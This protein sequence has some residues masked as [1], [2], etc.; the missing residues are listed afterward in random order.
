[1][2]DAVSPA[3]VAVAVVLRACDFGSA[4]VV[5]ADAAAAMVAA[6]GE[7]SA[8]AFLLGAFGGCSLESGLAGTSAAAAGG[9][10]LGWWMRFPVVR[11]TKIADRVVLLICFRR[12]RCQY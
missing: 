12:V 2:V 9:V 10:C 5:A 1:M 6:A 11:Y 4:V 7:M 8:A 3:M